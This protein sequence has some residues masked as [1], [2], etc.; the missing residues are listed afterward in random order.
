MKTETIL[1]SP[2]SAGEMAPRIKVFCWSDGLHVYTVAATSRTK[3]LAA[4]GFTRDLFR[5]GLAREVTSGA[6]Y[7]RARAKPGQVMER[8]AAAAL[9]ARPKGRSKQDIDKS[10]SRTAARRTLDKV[11]QQI[12]ALEGEANAAERAL[13]REQAVLAN[14][15]AATRADLAKR[16]VTLERKRDSLRAR[17]RGS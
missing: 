11:E 8:A 6:D 1:H 16:R 3:A 5:E 2:R 13:E 14:R 7:D 12:A 10:R 15:A 4:W 17:L 9:A